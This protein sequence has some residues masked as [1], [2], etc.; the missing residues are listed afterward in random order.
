MALAVFFQWTAC[1]KLTANFQLMHPQLLL[2]QSCVCPVN[3]T[4]SSNRAATPCWF[5]EVSQQLQLQQDYPGL[6]SEAPLLLDTVYLLSKLLL[7]LR[8]PSST[9]TLM[10][11]PLGAGSRESR[12]APQQKDAWPKAGRGQGRR[13]WA[14]DVF[15]KCL[16]ERRSNTEIA[17]VQSNRPSLVSI[18]DAL[19]SKS[20]SSCEQHT[21]CTIEVFTKASQTGKWL[22]GF[23]WQRVGE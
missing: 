13:E 5:C 4:P 12:L 11:A 18:T 6:Y 1:A 2:L 15:W 23:L 22:L 16:P 17:V 9:S 3:P 21:S 20:L 19:P 10:G 7:W 14:Y 8:S